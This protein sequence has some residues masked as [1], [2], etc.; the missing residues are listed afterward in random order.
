MRRAI[1][2]ESP[3]VPMRDFLVERFGPVPPWDRDLA[4][5]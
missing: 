5:A 2:L 4:A 1:M 3:S